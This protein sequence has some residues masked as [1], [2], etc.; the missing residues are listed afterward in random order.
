MFTSPRSPTQEENEVSPNTLR[1]KTMNSLKLTLHS[2]SG[3]TNQKQ[4]S[5]SK[6]SKLLKFTTILMD[7]D[8]RK[9]PS[10]SGYFEM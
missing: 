4:T 1:R 5:P 2:N 8:N 3:I 10:A 6:K 9:S 7:R